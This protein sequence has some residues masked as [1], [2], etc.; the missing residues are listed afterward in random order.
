MTSDE[1]LQSKQSSLHVE[2]KLLLSKFSYLS[3]VDKF[4]FF[5]WISEQAAITSLHSI[6]MTVFTTET[7]WVYC[8]V[9]T[10]SLN[11]IAVNINYKR[12]KSPFFLHIHAH[13]FPRHPFLIISFDALYI[14][15]TDSVV[16]QKK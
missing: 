2:S 16:K 14:S 15:L 13:H 11:I 1:Q 6:K 8:A 3:L 7:E 9:R 10:K 5:V 4:M 12:N